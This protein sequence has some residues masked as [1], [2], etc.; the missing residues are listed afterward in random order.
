ML[1]I[2]QLENDYEEKV[3]A[4][5]IQKWNWKQRFGQKIL[6]LKQ[7]EKLFCLQGIR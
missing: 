5:I 2:N 7:T 6:D 4:G 1:L 3:N